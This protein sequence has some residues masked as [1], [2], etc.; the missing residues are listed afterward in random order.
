MTDR[1]FTA[2]ELREV[3]GGEGTAADKVQA[4]HE[5]ILFPPRPTLADMTADERAECQ[6]MQAEVKGDDSRVVIANPYWMDG[7]A[8]VMGRDTR[9][10]AVPWASI[11]PRPDLPRLE[12]PGDTSE[13]ALPEG[14][15]L[16]DHPDYGRV[17]V[18][19]PTP[20][21]YGNVCFVAHVPGFIGNDWHLCDPDELKYLDQDAG[22]VTPARVGDTIESADDP[23]LPNLPVGSILLDRDGETVAK[24]KEEWVGLGRT[25]VPSEGGEFGPW[26]VIHTGLEADQ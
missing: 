13:P 6:R 17:I 2:A 15:K 7:S 14:W 8:R 22:D 24:R 4:L 19:S 26:E 20:D 9:M 21:A 5:L 1:T 12:W 23:R 11:T 16:A 18:T 25:P 3:L 10:R